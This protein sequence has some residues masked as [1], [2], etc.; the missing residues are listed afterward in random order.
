MDAIYNTFTSYEEVPR[1]PMTSPNSVGSFDVSRKWASRIDVP[2]MFQPDAA[3][4][5]EVSLNIGT[6]REWV[7][8][9]RQRTC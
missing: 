9:E 5:P 7:N 4:A 1:F 2:R 3:A 8:A 6:K